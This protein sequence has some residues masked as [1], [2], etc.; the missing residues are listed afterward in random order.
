MSALRLW[1][2]R[3]HQ[4]TYPDVL[5]IKGEP[6]FEEG[7]TDT[8]LNPAIIFE[9]LSKSTSSRD[10]GDKFTHYKSIKSFGEYLLVSQVRPHVTHFVKREGGMW[11]H[12]EFNDLED[13][14]QLASLECELRLRDVYTEVE[15]PPPTPPPAD[16]RPQDWER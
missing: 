3:Y 1:I 9:V 2:P 6:I 5:I 12:E 15:F 7:R 4:Y 14:V 13:V 11:L 16:E 8:V 10:R